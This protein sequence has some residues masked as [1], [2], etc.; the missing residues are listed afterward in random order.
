MY[1]YSNVDKIAGYVTRNLLCHPIRNNRG[2]G[3]IVA[4][5]ELINKVGEAPFDSNDEDVLAASVMRIID[6]LDT[7]FKELVDL[8]DSIA[9]FASPILPPSVEQSI[10]RVKGSVNKKGYEEPTKATVLRKNSREVG[11]SESSNAELLR[12]AGGGISLGAGDKRLDEKLKFVRRKSYGEALAQ[13]IS[14]NPE[15]LYTRKN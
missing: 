7:S 9:A 11:E 1:A 12:S 13:E 14:A 10:Q 6:E 3:R 8:N 15:L 2:G 5:V 4:V